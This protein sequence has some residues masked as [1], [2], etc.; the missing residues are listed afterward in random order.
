VKLRRFTGSAD[1][2]H[3]RPIGPLEEVELWAFTLDRPAI[4]L[5]SRQSPDVLDVEACRVAGVEIVRRRSG[6]GVVLLE[7]GAVEW[8]DIVVPPRSPWWVDDVVV[9]LV[10]SGRAWLEALAALRVADG[11]SV[12][13]GRL[14]RDALAD[15]VCFAGMGAGEVFTASGAKLVGM[16]QRRTRDGARV[17][18]LVHRRWNPA[19]LH[20][21]LAPGRPA[22][23]DVD[24]I[25]VATVDV[26]SDVLLDGLGVAV[27]SAVEAA[28]PGAD[29]A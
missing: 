14:R 16:S 26:D 22:G 19:L 20:H 9:T 10:R 4:V 23:P 17:Q 29:D 18:C 2:F 13:D 25:R 3:Q 24:A 11:L 8:V 6:G 7:P 1:E 21:L 15:L 5:G 12:Y 27:Q 28:A